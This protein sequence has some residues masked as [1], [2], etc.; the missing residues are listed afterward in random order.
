MRASTLHFLGMS[1]IKKTY[2]AFVLFFLLF[3]GLNG[4][5]KTALCF[6][7]KA[8]E[9]GIKDVISIEKELLEHI[10]K[11]R[12]KLSLSALRF[13]AELTALARKHSQDMALRQRLSHISSSGKTYRERIIKAKFFYVSAGENIARSE[14]FVAGFIHEEL[15][16]SAEHR[17]NTLEP[18]FD[19]AGIGVYLGKDN[20]YYITQDFLHSLEIREPKEVEKEIKEKINSCRRPFCPQQKISRRSLLHHACSHSHGQIQTS[21]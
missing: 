6:Q 19:M 10:N 15:M 3:A 9:T 18:S 1:R 16:K 13:S 11:E 5:G 2:P 12:E 7:Q 4:G 20:K 14:T 21:E 8:A 17:E